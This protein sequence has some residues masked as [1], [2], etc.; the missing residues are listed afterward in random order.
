MTS[1]MSDESV[2]EVYD[3]GNNTLVGTVPSASHEDVEHVLATASKACDVARNM[4][5]HLR[6]S[7]LRQVSEQLLKRHEEF[8]QVIAR[9]GIKTLREARKEVTRCVETL[10]ISA[11]EARRTGGG[12]NCFRPDAWI[13]KPVRLLQTSAGRVG[14]RHYTL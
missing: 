9:E 2:I 14:A 1:P 13:R 4:P 10:R 12:N 5:T 8:A 6:M 11:E 3:P 7:V